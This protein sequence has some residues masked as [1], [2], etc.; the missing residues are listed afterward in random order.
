MPLSAFDL[1]SIGIGPSSSHTVG[2]MRAAKRFVDGLVNDDQLS[3][4]RRVKAELFG[5]DDLIGRLTAMMAEVETRAEQAEA[6]IAEAVTKVEQAETR[7]EQALSGLR[8]AIEALL[9]ARGIPCPDDARAQVMACNDVAML[10]RWLL[11]ATT[12]GTVREVFEGGATP[13]T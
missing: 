6:R 13:G 8:Q 3:R 11:R 9:A 5:S 1:Y 12:A 7:A 10:Q 4:T 2:P